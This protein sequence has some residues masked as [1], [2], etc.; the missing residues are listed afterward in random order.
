MSLMRRILNPYL[1]VAEKR[2]LR[3]AKTPAALRRAFE[4][5]AR[6]FFHPRGRGF[7]KTEIGGVP[8]LQLEGNAPVLLYFHGGAYVFGSPNTHRAMLARIAR[9]TGCGV[10]L[11]NYRKAPEDPFPAAIEDA[12]TVYKAMANA[13]GGVVLGGDSAG[14]GLALALLAEIL[15]LGLPLPKGIFAL[16]PLT[17]LT[18]SADSLRTNAHSDVILPAERMSEMSQMFLAGHDPKD[19]CASPL[20]AEFRGAPP[21]WLC[22]ADTEILLD[23]TLRMAERLRARGVDVTEVI[24]HDLPH[25]WPIFHTLLPEAHRTLDQVSEWI[26]RLDARQSGS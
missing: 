15:R 21:V 3:T 24:E 8:C 19:P 23:D 4:W 6:L 26:R 9:R 25:V 7:R 14:G 11:P 2:R 17:D 16:S 10:V 1:R 20:F 12:L 5:N 13:P 22:A 18:V